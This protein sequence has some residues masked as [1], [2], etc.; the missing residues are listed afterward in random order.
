MEEHDSKLHF[1][2]GPGESMDKEKA[3]TSGEV[4]E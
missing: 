4:A 1:H 3:E 2:P